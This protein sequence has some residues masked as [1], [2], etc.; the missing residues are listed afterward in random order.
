MRCGKL[1]FIHSG[2]SIRKKQLGCTPEIVV[3]DSAD[4]GVVKRIIKRSFRNFTP[5]FAVDT[6]FPVQIPA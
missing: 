1:V 5:A 4:G 3:K 6:N 2:T